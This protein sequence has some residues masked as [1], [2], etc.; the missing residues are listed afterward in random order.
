MSK[1]LF[2]IEQLYYNT[3]LEILQ[4]QIKKT[5]NKFQNHL[6]LFESKTAGP[7]LYICLL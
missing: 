4:L 7:G 5:F 6:G 3:Y 1:T 2:V